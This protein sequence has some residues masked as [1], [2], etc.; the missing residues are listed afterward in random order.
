MAAAARA[1]TVR[2]GFQDW[3]VALQCLRPADRCELG[4]E[5]MAS[6]PIGQKKRRQVWL[7]V[8]RQSGGS[9]HASRPFWRFTPLTLC[10]PHDLQTPGQRLCALLHPLCGG[11]VLRPSPRHPA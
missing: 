5:A 1:W 3:R 11:L 6:E 8:A 2:C 7:T 10:R 4:G 9:L